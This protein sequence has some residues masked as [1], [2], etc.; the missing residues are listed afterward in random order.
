MRRDSFLICDHPFREPEW[1][2][3]NWINECEIDGVRFIYDGCSSS[4]LEESLDFYAN[5]FKP[6]MIYVGSGHRT[7]HNNHEQNWRELH[8]FFIKP[9]RIKE[10]RK[11][12]LK[13]LLN[14]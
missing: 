3:G 5:H 6:I 8:H 13:K 4:T 10:I 9:D 14:G 1:D 7:W 11:L 2:E 12:K